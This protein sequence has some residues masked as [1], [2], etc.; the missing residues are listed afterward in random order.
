MDVCT[1]QP[2]ATCGS[3]ANAWCSEV[4]GALAR[5]GGVKAQHNGVHGTVLHTLEAVTKAE[6]TVAGAVAPFS[7]GV[8]PSKRAFPSLP[9]SRWC[10][11]PQSCF[12]DGAWYFE[13]DDENEVNYSSQAAC[14]A[15]CNANSACLAAVWNAAENLCFHPINV[16]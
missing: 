2:P 8:H 1:C 15:A 13:I 12:V 7:A 3:G 16:R 5:A 4:R 9:I 14:L 10:A 6:N 11:Q